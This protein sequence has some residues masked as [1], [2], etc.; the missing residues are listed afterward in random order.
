VQASTS[1]SWLEPM[2]SMAMGLL[3]ALF[4]DISCSVR[5]CGECRGGGADAEPPAGPMFEGG[6]GGTIPATAFTV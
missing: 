1:F 6:D 4:P 5:M 2:F 3:G